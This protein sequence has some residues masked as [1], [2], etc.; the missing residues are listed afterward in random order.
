MKNK[1]IFLTSLVS[2]LILSAFAIPSFAAA[3]SSPAEVASAVTE[4]PLTE[5]VEERASG[6]TYGEIAAEEG[7][8]SDF[9][10]EM[11]KIKEERLQSRVD[12]GRI[13]QEEADEIL[14]QVAQRQENCDGTGRAD[15]SG[16]GLGLGNGQGLGNCNGEGQGQ[17]KG[18]CR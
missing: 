11:L 6:K 9:K 12:S 2:L 10:E 15:G 16:Q 8:L 1:K 3:Y 4:K 14:A 5:V 17:G 18:R 7:K 13:T